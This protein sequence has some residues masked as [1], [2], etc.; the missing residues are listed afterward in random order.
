M[1]HEEV[2]S[3]CRGIHLEEAEG[4]YDDNLNQVVRTLLMEANS[5]RNE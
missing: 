1:I 2:I 3:S 5:V 4:F